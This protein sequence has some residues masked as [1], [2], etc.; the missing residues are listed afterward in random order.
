MY[1]KLCPVV[2]V[3][4]W[5]RLVAVQRRTHLAAAVQRWVCL[6]AAV[7]GRVCLVAAVVKLMVWD[8]QF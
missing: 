8:L 6:V 1:Q 7:Q 5:M 2:V 3:Q 4:L